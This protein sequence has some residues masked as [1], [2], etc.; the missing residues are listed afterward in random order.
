MVPD[1]R[2]GEKMRTKRFT[3]TVAF[4]L[5]QDEYEL[6]EWVSAYNG[7]K[8]VSETVRVVLADRLDMWRTMRTNEVKK[9]E[10]AAKRAAKKVATTDAV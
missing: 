4:R 10:A 3:K 6:L 7:D 1:R 8:N 2:L 5:T 9:L